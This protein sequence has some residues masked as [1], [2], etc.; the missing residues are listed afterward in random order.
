MHG[1]HQLQRHAYPWVLPRWPLECSSKRALSLYPIAEKLIDLEKCC[2]TA[3]SSKTGQGGSSCTV[4]TT[5]KTGTCM[6]TA[7]CSGTSTPGFCPNGPTDVQVSSATPTIRSIPDNCEPR[8]WQVCWKVL[9]N[10]LP[11]RQQQW[12]R[13]LHGQD[14][15][16]DRHMHLHN[17]LCKIKRHLY[18]WVLPQWFHKCSG[19]RAPY[20]LSPKRRKIDGEKFFLY[21]FLGRGVFFAM[22]ITHDHCPTPTRNSILP[23]LWTNNF[24]TYI[25][26]YLRGMQNPRGR[27]WRVYPYTSV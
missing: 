9:Y 5:G 18:S 13:H 12:R 24:P 27:K 11:V 19:K 6:A 17:P 25:V 3:T 10:F 20:Q 8:N 23:N 22:K 14:H 2:T 26:L 4:K 7:S 21:F 15:R 16:K 1:H